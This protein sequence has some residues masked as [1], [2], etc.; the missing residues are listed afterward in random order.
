MLKKVQLTIKSL[1][2]GPP[3][4]AASDNVQPPVSNEQHVSARW[5]EDE[6]AVS[7][8][9]DESDEE[10][11]ETVQM[12]FYFKK[13]DPGTVT[14]SRSGSQRYQLLFRHGQ[15]C[16]SDYSVGGMRLEICAVTRRLQNR[17]RTNGTLHLEYTIEL[18]GCS[19]GVRIVDLSVEDAAPV[20]PLREYH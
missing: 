2:Y 18:Q 7:L 12:Q 6:H 17:L 8:T 3:D 5:R 19:N 1:Q 10:G 9:Y 20:A 4:E 16:T 11:K 15:R 13:S 14:L